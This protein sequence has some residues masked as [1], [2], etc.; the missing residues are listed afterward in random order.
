MLLFVLVLARHGHF[1]GIKQLIFLDLELA[2][3]ERA[4]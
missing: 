4:G 2:G 3:T 1:F